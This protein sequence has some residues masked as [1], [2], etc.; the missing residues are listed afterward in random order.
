MAHCGVKDVFARRGV[1]CHA[2]LMC[3]I[4]QPHLYF[5][6]VLFSGS[7]A[8]DSV[9]SLS[10]AEADVF[11]VCYKISDPSSLYNVKTKWIP[12]LRHFRSDVPVILCGCQADLRADP[13]VIAGLAKRGRAPVT[14]EQAL[15][16]CCEVGAANYVETSSMT[17]EVTEAFEVAAMAAS[18]SRSY[19]FNTTSSNHSSVT[20][21]KHF[22]TTAS[23][24]S[25]YFSSFI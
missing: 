25:K 4:T 22:N 23:S 17:L 1:V 11:L 7:P 14:P 9:R 19:K 3:F 15:A 12:E 20:S 8:Y 13:E 21:I 5:C 2:I 6:F 10:Y 18:R 24:S 16:I